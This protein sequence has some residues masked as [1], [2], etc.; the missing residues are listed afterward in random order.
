M[1]STRLAVIRI[2]V[3]VLLF[4]AILGLPLAFLATGA[5]A[6][7][8]SLAV[9]LGQLNWG[10]LGS[11]SR[12]GLSARTITKF[13]GFNS[14][15]ELVPLG[16][17]AAPSPRVS[18]LNGHR[19]QHL[20][21]GLEVIGSQVIETVGP[22][23]TDVVDS[24]SSFDLSPVPSL[25]PAEAV[26]VALSAS[27][28]S[29]KSK[30]APVLKVLPGSNELAPSSARL[31]YE[32]HVDG[33]ISFDGSRVWIDAHTAAVISVVPHHIEIFPVD[34]YSAKAQQ[35][36]LVCGNAPHIDSCR[37]MYFNRD[38]VLS[39]PK[40]VYGGAVLPEADDASKRALSHA[41]QAIRYYKIVH[42]R[43]G[44]DDQGTRVE[45]VVHVGRNFANAYWSTSL[46]Y[47]GYGD[48]DGRTMGDPTLARDIAGHEFTHAVIA[49]T[50]GLDGEG[51][52]GA[53]NE[54]LADLFGEMI[55]GRLDWKMGADASLA[56]NPQE[57]ALRDLAHPQNLQLMGMRYP[58]LYSE[59]HDLRADDGRCDEDRCGIHLNS[60]IISHAGYLMYQR[61]GAD[62]EQIWYAAL[63]GYL[64]QLSTFSDFAS[65]S[66]AACSQLF[67][68][69][70][71]D[72][73]ATVQVFEELGFPLRTIQG[74]FGSSAFSA[75]RVLNLR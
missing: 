37:P 51:M 56:L 55:E 21:H 30:L 71:N 34:V 62:A 18:A 26:A 73:T 59:Y 23:G 70:S 13:R 4:G 46:G 10:G 33:G 36:S 54:G 47:M 63:T 35:A 8:D 57:H 28:G 5:W 22:H 2:S 20:F 15:H 12:F 6:Q 7:Q 31:I 69:N 74:G 19:F 44:F 1:L 14:F 60:T 11:V 45:N 42:G 39:L 53:L 61:I 16:L 38:Q 50:A 17:Q 41:L 67:G 27:P 43:D 65:A 48:G 25:R 75:D 72:C 3:S 58:T 40:S 68:V 66:V 9:K 32:V 29:R 64:T 49:S 52:A 24:L